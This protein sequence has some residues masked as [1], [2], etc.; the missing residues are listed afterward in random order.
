MENET[1]KFKLWHPAIIGVVAVLLTYPT[2]ALLAAINAHYLGEKG[3]KTKYILTGI[4]Y[5]LVFWPLGL[6]MMDTWFI[7]LNFV[8]TIALAYLLYQESKN[9]LEKNIAA[10]NIV[11]QNPGKVLLV[12]MVFFVATGLCYLLFAILMM[13]FNSQ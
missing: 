3:K 9:A 4:L 5:V 1:P 7:V 8:V 2:G 12:I 13:T 10:D 11:Y 6:F